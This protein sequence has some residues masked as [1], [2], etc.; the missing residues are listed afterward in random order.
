MSECIV[1]FI[2]LPAYNNHDYAL[3]HQAPG[4]SPLHARGDNVLVCIVTASHREIYQI[5]QWLQL[6]MTNNWVC[7]DSSA[8]NTG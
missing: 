7:G 3:L 5:A 4:H 1:S 8:V 2:F 6:H